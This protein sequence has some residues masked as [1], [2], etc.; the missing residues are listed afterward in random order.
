[1]K[2]G[3]VSKGLRG[4][5]MVYPRGK[6]WWLQYFIRGQRIRESSGSSNRADAVKLLKQRT[7]EAGNGKPV[8]PQVEKTRFEDLAGMLV[9]DYRTN[10]RKSLA[11]IEDALGHLRVFF[12]D[13]RAHDVT[14]DRVTSY[15]AFRQDE[16][17]ANAT[18]NREL[19][20][21][22]RAF[23]LAAKARKVALLPEITMLEED[24]AREGFVEQ[25]QFLTLRE[26][27]PDDLKDPITFLWL[28]GWR[29]GEMRSLRW[30]SVYSDAIRLRR[31][32]SKNKRGR[33]LPLVGELAE[34]IER[35][36][37]TRRPECAHV[38]NRDGQPIGSFRKSWITACR[39][40][41]LGD[42][43][44]HDLRRSAARNLIRAGVSE[45]I[46]QQ[47]T[48]HKTASVFRRY[49]IITERDLAEAAARLE[50]HLAKQP[51]RPKTTSLEEAR[52]RRTATEQ[53]QR[54]GTEL[55]E[56]TKSA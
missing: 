36:R 19:A 55:G 38:F 42:L 14:S 16:K 33:E 56:A 32:N 12:G 1:M 28:T 4:M 25:A 37:T 21:L 7:A 18:I 52:L 6:T 13:F 8:G 45:H 39:K 10:R 53:P 41:G 9:S 44:V 27:L 30:Q 35:A 24:N 48:G 3:D 47:F 40:A 15:V 46:A 11:R 17:A 22:K 49:D 50:Q 26:A 5:G 2:T 31:E 20:A 43:R 34:V 23:H 29:V 51:T 54:P